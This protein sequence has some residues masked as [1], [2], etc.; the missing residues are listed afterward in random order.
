MDWWDYFAAVGPSLLVRSPVLVAWIVGI[1]IAARMLKRGG[2]KAERLLLIGCSLMFAGQLIAPFSQV[3]V[4]WLIVERTVPVE[5]AAFI[6]S[7][8]NLPL[9]IISLAGIV[10]L[11]YAFWVRWKSHRVI[12]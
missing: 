5:R 2:G 12:P 9:G 8:I 10:S 1:I 4:T 11:V 3:L 6:S 7:I